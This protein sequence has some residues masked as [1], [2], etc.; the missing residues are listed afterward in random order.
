YE[1]RHRIADFKTPLTSAQFAETFPALLRRHG[2]RSGFIGKWGLGE[3]LPGAEYDFFRGFPGQGS[4][5]PKG[6]FGQPGEHLTAKQAAQ[7][8]EFLEG[9]TPDK[10]FVLQ[11]STKAP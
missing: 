5:F 2:Y 8:V 3:P 10:P 6:K 9:C 11:I 1:R 4:Y 7:A